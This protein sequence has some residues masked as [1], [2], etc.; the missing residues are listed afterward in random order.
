LP[1]IN[2]A[3]V[4]PVIIVVAHLVVHTRKTKRCAIILEQVNFDK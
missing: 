2:I 4:R 3:Y 1:N